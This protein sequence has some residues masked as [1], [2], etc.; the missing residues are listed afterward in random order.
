MW[1]RLLCMTLLL[2]GCSGAPV[3]DVSDSTHDSATLE[4]M[5]ADA[6]AERVVGDSMCWRPD[7]EVEAI[8]G[9][10]RDTFGKVHARW[11]WEAEFRDPLPES[12][13]GEDSPLPLEPG[14]C[15]SRIILGE[16]HDKYGNEGLGQ[17]NAATGQGSAAY[18]GGASVLTLNRRLIEEGRLLDVNQH[19]CEASDPWF[20][21]LAHVLTHELAHALGLGHNDN[22][23]SPMYDHPDEGDAGVDGFTQLCRDP[24]PTE[25]DLAAAL[26]PGG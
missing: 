4:L 13:F 2:L 20:Y 8:F 17:H 1:G 6:G 9:T 24:M 3:G 23:E 22:P 14:D 7:A 21:L 12:A 26:H 15:D 19:G 25:E 5:P 11:G 10:L 16:P 18:V